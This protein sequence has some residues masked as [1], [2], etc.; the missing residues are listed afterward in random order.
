[1]PC[2]PILLLQTPDLNSG[3]P[4][5][6]LPTRMRMARDHAEHS[7]TEAHAG[8]ASRTPSLHGEPHLE[9]SAIIH[10]FTLSISRTLDGFLISAIQTPH[11]PVLATSYRGE[12]VVVD[13]ASLPH[14]SRAS[15]RTSNFGVEDSSYTV[16][17]AFL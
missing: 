5:G 6:R 1:M 9:C 2:C 13:A 4:P 8:L 11:Y 3:E 12:L 17:L 16:A 14:M 10:R 15:A 7:I